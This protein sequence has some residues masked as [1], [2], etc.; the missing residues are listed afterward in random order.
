MDIDITFGSFN[1]TN[2]P[3]SFKKTAGKIMAGKTAEG[4]KDNISLLFELNLFGLI[5]KIELNLVK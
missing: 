5:I 2:K 3:S 1:W 4:T